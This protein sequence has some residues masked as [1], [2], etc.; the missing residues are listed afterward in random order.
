MKYLPLM[1]AVLAPITAFAATGP[2]PLGKT[3]GK[4]GNWTAATYG[5]GAAKACYAFTNAQS[6]K[7]SLKK[8]GAVMLTVV[9]RKAAKDEVTLTAGYVYPEKAAVS[10]KINDKSI[11]FYTKGETAFTSSGA[12]AIAAF[13]HGADAVSAATGPGG[14]IVTD[15]FSLTGFSGAY[16]AITAACP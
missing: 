12:D 11:D 15:T 1:L 16:S 8:R 4:F 6:S 9:E 5:S 10:L 2:T 7:P 3:N 14:K 13:Q